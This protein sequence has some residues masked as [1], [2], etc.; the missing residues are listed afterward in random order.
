M[1]RHRR[2][3]GRNPLRSCS[4]FAIL[5]SI[6]LAIASFGCTRDNEVVATS[7]NTSSLSRSATSVP[8]PDTGTTA[9]SLRD[10]ILGG[11]KRATRYL[12]DIGPCIQLQSTACF[13][14]GRLSY[15]LLSGELDLLAANISR[16]GSSDLADEAHRTADFAVL[17]ADF[18]KACPSLAAPAAP[19]PDCISRNDQVWQQIP[20]LQHDL[21]SI[22]AKA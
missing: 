1:R 6:I 11:T 15:F 20:Q 14:Q 17:L 16:Q 22:R 21:E 4:P 19:S 5:L 8:V 12:A 2:H 10:Q 13:D 7:P 3:T 9:L 18:Y